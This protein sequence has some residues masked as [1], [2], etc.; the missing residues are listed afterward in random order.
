MK[1]INTKVDEVTV[2]L[3]RAKIRRS[4]KTLVQKGKQTLSI[5][6]LPAELDPDS[7]RVRATGSEPVT[8]YGID[9]RR[10]FFKDIPDGII[11]ELTE[12]IE[13]LEEK[14]KK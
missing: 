10:T 8:I 5:T 3:N 7:V 4:G 12:N 2:F 1:E 11:R 13:K 6:G 9:V 14:K